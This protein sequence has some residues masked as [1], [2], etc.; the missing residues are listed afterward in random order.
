MRPAPW[1]AR[2]LRIDQRAQVVEAVGGDHARGHQFPQRGFDFGF[3]FS[4][5]ANDVGEE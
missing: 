4:R 3:Q 5:A 2:R 1:P